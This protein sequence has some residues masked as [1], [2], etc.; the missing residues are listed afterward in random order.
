M[1]KNAPNRKIGLVTFNNEVTVIGDGTKHPQTISG[2]KLLDFEFLRT[3]GIQSSQ[4]LF[5]N[6]IKDTLKPL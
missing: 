4:N 3:N 5:K 2:D 6:S 1:A